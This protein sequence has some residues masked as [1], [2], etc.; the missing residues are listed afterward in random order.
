MVVFFL[1]AFSCKTLLKTHKIDEQN[2]RF[3]GIYL[4]SENAY[5]IS[6]YDD[7][8]K[9]LFIDTVPVIGLKDIEKVK[10]QKD[11][12]SNMPNLYIKLTDNAKSTF[13]KITK[14]HINEQ[15]AVILNDK[16]VMAPIILTEITSGELTISGYKLDSIFNEFINTFENYTKSRTKE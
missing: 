8:S 5:K 9:F 16:L 1:F 4:I 15:L 7:S 2:Y 12:Y 11:K 6:F 10:K 13:A 3:N 14:E